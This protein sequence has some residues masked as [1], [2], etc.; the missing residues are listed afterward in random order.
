MITIEVRGQEKLSAALLRKK[1]NIN[2]VQQA[3]AYGAEQIRGEAIRSIQ[4]GPKTGRVYKRRRIIHRASAPGE[5]P[6]TDTGRLV[7]SIFARLFR[8]YAEVGTN[9]KYGAYL[10]AG[11]GRILPR[12]WL[13][14]AYEKHI[15]TVLDRINRVVREIM[16]S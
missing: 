2:R 10:E 16:R 13:R 1:G 4:K 5:P 14:P 3:I 7:G 11:T 12:P 9:V 6:A 8:D 15:R